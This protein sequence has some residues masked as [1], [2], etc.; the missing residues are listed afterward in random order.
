[1]RYGWLWLLRWL[2]MQEGT[3]KQQHCSHQISHSHWLPHARS[4]T[5]WLLVAAATPLINGSLPERDVIATRLVWG[6]A[7]PKL[8]TERDAQGERELTATQLSRLKHVLGRS[9]LYSVILKQQ[10]DDARNKHAAERAASP[11]KAK[12]KSKAIAKPAKPTR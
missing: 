10:M 4:A 7:P 1:M 9:N 5:G 8:T 6:D 11:P 2:N 12:E 3:H